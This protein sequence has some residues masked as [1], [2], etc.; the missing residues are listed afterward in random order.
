MSTTTSG[1]AP[2]ESLSQRISA[3]EVGEAKTYAT[4][5]TSGDPDSPLPCWG[6]IAQR[7][8]Q[9]FSKD[10]ERIAILD[11]LIAEGDRRPLYLFLETSRQRP[12]LM[13]ELCQRAK[14]LPVSVQRNLVAMPEAEP[15]VPIV[16]DQLDR[17]ALTVWMGSPELKRR[18]RELLAG[19][20]GTLMAFQYFVPD[21]FQPSEELEQK[22]AQQAT[23][24]AGQTAGGS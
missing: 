2:R 18:E 10:E 5:I 11:Q 1:A 9:S 7:F 24:Q 12:R 14:E 17:S 20:V 6:A 21:N 15:Y 8:E 3:L 13:V 16:I 4:F 19:R 22:T 23:Q